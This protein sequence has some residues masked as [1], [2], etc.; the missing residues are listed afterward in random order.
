[1]TLRVSRGQLLQG[2]FARMRHH[3]TKTLA[4]QMSGNNFTAAV[5]GH[6]NCEWVSIN[7]LKEYFAEKNENSIW[8]SGGN[9]KEAS[10]YL[11]LLWY[12][13]LGKH[14]PDYHS[15]VTE[16]LP[17]PPHIRRMRLSSKQPFK[18]MMFFLCETLVSLLDKMWHAKQFQSRLWQ[19]KISVPSEASRQRKYQRSKKNIH[20]FILCFY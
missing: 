2:P 19:L 16:I 20:T 14:H 15:W 17:L 9:K 3:V 4:F 6:T 10:A 13:I 11:V 5:S 7:E 1:M 18:E 8:A 12:S